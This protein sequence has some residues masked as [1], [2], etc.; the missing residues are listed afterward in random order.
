[1][2]LAFVLLYYFDIND[3]YLRRCRKKSLTMSHIAPSVTTGSFSTGIR[4]VGGICWDL[5]AQGVVALD[6]TPDHVTAAA[7]DCQSCIFLCLELQRHGY[8]K[9]GAF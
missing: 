4:E 7:R 2:Y 1:M 9:T 8:R 3:L 6:L 5:L